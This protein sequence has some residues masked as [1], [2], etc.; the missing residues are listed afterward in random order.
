MSGEFFKKFWK[1]KFKMNGTQK[2]A[3][4]MFA[5][6]QFNF[7]LKHFPFYFKHLKEDEK[8]K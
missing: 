3:E 6:L 1:K 8:C 2:K 4:H 5:P 7:K